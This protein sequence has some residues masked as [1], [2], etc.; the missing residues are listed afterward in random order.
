MYYL[1]DIFKTENIDE[2]DLYVIILDL[3]INKKLNPIESKMFQKHLSEFREMTKNGINIKDAIPLILSEDEI[4]TII[5]NIDDNESFQ[6]YE[7]E[8]KEKKEN[9]DVKSR[10]TF[11]EKIG[12]GGFG[13]VFLAIDNNNGNQV[14]IKE[15]RKR[16][17]NEEDINEY[18]KL[19]K[20]RD[21][22]K[23]YYVCV[24][25]YYETDTYIYIVMEYLS[26]YKPLSNYR[27]TIAYANQNWFLNRETEDDKIIINK[28]NEIVTEIAK[29]IN[30][31]HSIEMVHG[32]IKPDNILCDF[33]TGKIKFIDFGLS[34]ESD[35]C[36]VTNKDNIG[37][38]DVFYDPQLRNKRKLQSTNKNIIITL[39][40]RMMSDIWSIGALYYDLFL[41]RTPMDVYLD[42]YTSL[43][44][45]V[46][47]NEFYNTY[48]YQNDENRF[49]VNKIMNNLNPNLNMDLILNIDINKRKL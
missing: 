15:I 45:D 26:N 42:K 9:D 4:A 13:T 6:I 8:L 48:N 2:W 46:R 34:C 47:K 35:D 1:S 11:K 49:Y 27:K 19:K 30:Y 33:D 40:D 28:T 24:H 10:Y 39:K 12:Q 20:L 5:D 22:C 16:K 44:R 21:K 23:L 38:T 25:E 31:L 41:M 36:I 43:E 29:A 32:D 14:A 18:I 17:N 7:K 3:I 37:K